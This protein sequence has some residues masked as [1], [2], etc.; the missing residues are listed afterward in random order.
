M[1]GFFT[2]KETESKSRP[3]GKT[4]SCASCGLYRDCENPRMKPFGN[5]AKGILNI[6]EAPGETEDTR[7][8]QW[9]GKT[10]RL[11]QKT[12]RRLGIDLFEDCLNINAVNCRPVDSKGN[13]RTPTNYEIDCCRR[14]VIK[15]IEQ[16][17]PK[18]IVLLGGSALY[19][20]LGH[21]WKKNLGGVTKWRGWCI[22]DQDFQ[23]WICPVFHPSYVERGEQEVE[24]VWVQDLKQVIEIIN[25]PF[26]KF[27]EP[28]IRIIDDLTPL[29]E[30]L[31]NNELP[32]AFDY[33][34]T[35]LKPY[36]RGHRIV[37][38]S[39]AVN[40]DLCFA[41][42][43]PKS[44][45]GHQPWIN[46]LANPYIAKMAQNMKFEE[47]WSVVR[48]GQSVFNWVWD[49]MQ[50]SHIL[51]NRPLITGLKFQAYVQFGIIDYDS[52]ISPYLQA[53]DNGG[54]TFNRIMELV[55]QPGGE[56]KLLTYCAWD[57]V[58]EYRLALL[59]QELINRDHL[60]F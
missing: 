7:G 36:A 22:P 57:S 44:K 47:A 4:Y 39:A 28:E 58:L 16:Y 37:C 48:L 31:N 55:E 14:M 52:E 38:A 3:D 19:T 34:T 18:V 26:L 21:R 6:G 25:K 59:Q 11:L 35:G 56:E 33:E 50:A 30:Y 10:G 60:P 1:E 9:Q 20:I 54:N 8:K 2:R 42:M 15:C 51:D 24:T 5:F 17:K 12:Y 41:F 46:I 23:T 40:P 45:Q 29:T 13:N 27:I 49:T 43:M 32:I 53:P